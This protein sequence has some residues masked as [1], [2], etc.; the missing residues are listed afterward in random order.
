[1]GSSPLIVFVALNNWI[2]SNCYNFS[3]HFPFHQQWHEEKN[4]K[5][6][7]FRWR[8]ETNQ[9]EKYIWNYRESGGKNARN[10][11]NRTDYAD[12][13]WC[14]GLF[15]FENVPN[16]E[17]NPSLLKDM[18]NNLFHALVSI[19]TL[20]NGNVRKKN[21]YIYEHIPYIK[22]SQNKFPKWIYY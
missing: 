17:K 2:K 4:S 16:R 22:C 11:K 9:S 21:Q 10:E 19:K 7:K 14:K 5:F 8:K 18:N 1:M 15:H 6:I 12:L 20:Q 3:W 13:V